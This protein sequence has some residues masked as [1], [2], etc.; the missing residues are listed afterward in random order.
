M[1]LYKFYPV[2][3]DGSN[4]RRLLIP[5]AAKSQIRQF[6]TETWGVNLPREW[7]W[8]WYIPGLGTIGNRIEHEL[9]T[10]G[11]TMSSGQSVMLRLFAKEELSPFT[12]FVISNEMIFGRGQAND[13]ESPEW[14]TSR[15]MPE[16]WQEVDGEYM[17]IYSNGVRDEVVVAPGWGSD[18]FN[19]L[20]ESDRKSILVNKAYGAYGRCLIK[21]NYPIQGVHLILNG[22]SFT[23]TTRQSRL[24]A[25]I[26]CSYTEGEY[27]R[28]EV[29]NKGT[30]TGRFAIQLTWDTVADTQRP[31]GYLVGSTERLERVTEER[32]DLQLSTPKAR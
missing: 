1:E 9:E 18:G 5:D 23:S 28:V 27:R 8:D 4:E 3:Y 12:H 25:R 21:R 6:L 14:E 16:I 10:Q 20:S 7:K 29:Y 31:T 26:L 2:Y 22:Y 15:R 30:Y 32:I 24:F 19:G 11:Y 17:S 13:H